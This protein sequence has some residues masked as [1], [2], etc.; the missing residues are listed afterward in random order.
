MQETTVQFVDVAEGVGYYI[1]ACQWRKWAV[2]LSRTH[3]IQVQAFLDYDGDEDLDLYIVNS[4]PLPGFVTG[5]TAYERALSER[6][7]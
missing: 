4:A 6:W 7:R 5:Y 1:Q 2:I 3:G